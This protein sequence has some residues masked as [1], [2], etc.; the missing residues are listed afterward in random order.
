MFYKVLHLA[1]LLAHL[2]QNQYPNPGRYSGIHRDWLGH[3]SRKL[4]ALISNQQEGNRKYLDCN[5]HLSMQSSPGLLG[6]CDISALQCQCVRLLRRQCC[7]EHRYR[8]GAA[9]LTHPIHLASP[10]KSHPEDCFM[11]RI[12]AWRLVCPHA[13]FAS[14]AF[15]LICDVSICIISIVRLSIMST[16][17]F[18]TS[19][20][21]VTWLFND[22]STWTA[23]ETN[24]GIVSGVFSAVFHLC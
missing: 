12:L 5:H 20:T 6:P 2:W 9:D 21:D 18:G 24:M 14:T 11:W 7:S 17:L 3:I 1:V 15:S 10:S 22:S 19:S 8:L 16:Q 23:V 4:R 13:T